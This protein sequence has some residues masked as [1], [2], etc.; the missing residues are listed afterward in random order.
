[1]VFGERDGSRSTRA[2][3]L[4]DV[5]ARSRIDWEQSPAIVQTMWDKIVFLAALASLTCLF[6]GNVR[7]IMAAPGGRAAA[8]RAL[9][10]NLAIAAAEGF[11]CG[12]GA[13]TFAR[14]RLTDPEGLQSA[15]MMRDLEA[16]GRVESE[17]IVG[18]ML[19]RARRHGIDDTM[20]SLA[21]THLKTY[22][23]RR[24]AGRLPRG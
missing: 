5:F 8:E 15:S 18:W 13:M 19:E 6:R 16:G 12:P 10:A 7:E 23:A 2:S 9:D 3:A 22:E 24:E 4:A 20:L 21:Y 17:H 14:E 11:P 1:L